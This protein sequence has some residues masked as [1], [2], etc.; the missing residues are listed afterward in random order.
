MTGEV[1]INEP[2][3]EAAQ[4]TTW[5]LLQFANIETQSLGLELGTTTIDDG[6]DTVS[7]VQLADIGL[8]GPH[9]VLSFTAP[10]DPPLESQ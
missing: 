10:Y 8:I 7:G 5:T 4:E 2:R 9:A 3:F 1:L 6:S